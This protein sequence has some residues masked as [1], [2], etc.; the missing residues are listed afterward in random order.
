MFYK[1]ENKLKS[2]FRIV[3]FGILIWSKPISNECEIHY[4]NLVIKQIKIVLG[5]DENLY[6]IG[7]NIKCNLIDIYM[8]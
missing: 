1:N 8:C 3:I 2:T 5:D 4:L 7:K 6:H